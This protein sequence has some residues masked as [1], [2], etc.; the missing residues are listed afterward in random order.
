MNLHSVAPTLGEE[1]SLLPNIHTWY[2]KTDLTQAPR[3]LIPSPC[4]LNTCVFVNVY[5]FLSH[6]IAHKEKLLILNLTS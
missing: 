1:Q 3:F 2:I 4:L 6:V 5:V